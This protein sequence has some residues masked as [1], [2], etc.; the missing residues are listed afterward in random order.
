MNTVTPTESKTEVSKKRRQ[1]RG[2]VVCNKS[3]KTVSVRIERRVRHPL[4]EKIIR[5]HSKVQAHDEHN[6]CQVG[7]IITLEETPRFSK[8]KS[9]LVI[10]QPSGENK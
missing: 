6:R 10:E 5:R 9:W 8:T 2:V 4:Y 3:D 7:D 1:L